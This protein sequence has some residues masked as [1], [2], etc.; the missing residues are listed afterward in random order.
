MAR[1]RKPSSAQLHADWLALVEITGAFLSVP[2]LSE[3]MPEGPQRPSE[4]ELAAEF[5]RMREGYEADPGLRYTLIDWVLREFLG[6][7]DLVA[8]DQQVREAHA[9]VVEE[10]AALITPDRVIATPSDPQTPLAYV[11]ITPIGQHPDRPQR[12]GQWSSTPIDRATMLARARGV[13]LAFITDGDRWTLLWAPP[14]EASGACT[15]QST[16]LEEE[17]TALNAFWSIAAR[18][19]TAGM[20]EESLLPLLRRSKDEQQELTDQLGVQVR[21]AVEMLVDALDASLRRRGPDAVAAVHGQTLYRAAVTAVMRLIVA[22]V[23]EERKLLPIDDPSYAD[24]YAASTIRGQL[25]QRVARFGEEVLEKSGDAWLRTLALAR[26]IHGGAE[27]AAFR[28]P[29]YGGELFDPDRFPFLEG[30]PDG[31]SWRDASGAPLGVDDRTMLHLLDALQTLTQ[32]GARGSDAAK[33]RISY[34]GIDVEQIGYVYEGLLDHSAVRSDGVVLGIDGKH[35]PEITLAELETKRAEGDDAFAKWLAKLSGLSAAKITKALAADID[36]RDRASRLLVACGNDAALR[37]RVLPFADLLR[38]DL[39]GR[40]RVFLPGTAF[41]TQSSE[42]GD[43]GTYYTPRSLAEEVVGHALTPLVFSPGPAETAARAEW[44]LR[45]P[46]ELLD[47]RI[48]D[49]AMGSGAFLVAAARFLAQHVVDAW[50]HLAAQLPEGSPFTATGAPGSGTLTD[51]VVPADPLEREQLALRLV[52]ERCIYG[53]DIN[54][55]AVEMAKLSLWL[56]TL[57]KDRPFSF[58]DHA[59]RAGDSLLGVVEPRQLEQLRLDPSESASLDD[60]LID[61]REAMVRAADK[62]IE[63]EQYGATHVR[64]E[65]RKAELFAEAE[66]MTADLTL[67][68]DAITGAA[69]LGPKETTAARDQLSPELQAIAPWLGSTSGASAGI[70]P[71]EARGRVSGRAAKWLAVGLPDHARDPRRPLHWPLAFPEIV[72]RGGFDAIVGNPPFLGGSKLTGTFGHAYRAYLVSSV[73]EGQRGNADLVAYMTLRAAALTRHGST[74]GLIATNTL[75]Q[76]DTREVGL[77]RLVDSGRVIVQAVRSRPWPARGANLEICSVTLYE[78]AWMGLHY[79]EGCAAATI[80]PS[81]V[82]GGRVAGTPQRLAA[83]AGCAFV[84]T[85]VYGQGFVLS[86]AERD[87]LL[88]RDAR[89]AEVIR[90]YLIGE[91]LNQRPDSSPSRFVID[92]GT[93]TLE[94]A[95][96]HE[97]CFARVE[98]LVYPERSRNNRAVRRER[99]WQFGEPAHGLYRAI[100]GLDRCIAITLV[101]KVVQP[102]MV[103]TGAVFAHAT[104]VFASDDPGLFGLLSSG[105]HWWWSVERASTM[106]ND[107]RYTPTDCFETLVRPADAEGLRSLGE[108]LHTTRS[109]LMVNRRLGLTDVYNRIHDPAVVDPGIERLRKL[110]RELD[111]AVLAAYGWGDLDPGHGFHDT[112]FGTRYTFEPVVRQEVLD[113]LLELNFERY[114]EEVAQGLHDKKHSKTKRGKAATRRAP[115]PN[116]A[117]QEKIF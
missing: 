23:A 60:A 103:P 49:I 56:V 50:D 18:L 47:L 81:L 14:G 32:K 58:L 2:V 104:A 45:A 37:N 27:H 97:A 79:L 65:Q 80:T 75:A 71:G 84:G 9:H 116:T 59:L 4:P 112:R 17:A 24:A 28:L 89:S 85:K 92:F 55:M 22:F 64:D 38:D 36:D 13:E 10:H 117:G 52:V 107:V 19:R 91:D 7:R 43:S 76:G 3:V 57:Q 95:A 46:A 73:A 34:R 20:G 62:R 70:D 48:C 53:V 94:E 83:N 68:A 113:R 29:A 74:V 87:E 44:R 40:P 98:E 31:S 66:A 41:V 42:R 93:R 100:T 77:D 39:R 69:L 51:P 105:A 11:H 30:R 82:R 63:I 61:V 25:Q 101:S 8:S 12:V 102:V 86:T 115:A 106:R 16:I 5:R 6:Y 15:W 99:W 54:P 110:H 78:G 109:E 108:Q 88:A 114:A 33:V 26:V 72:G 67:I 111:L 90:P 1:A 21:H 35:E 96:Q